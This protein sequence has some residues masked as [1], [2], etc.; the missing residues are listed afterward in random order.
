MMFCCKFQSAGHFDIKNALH[1]FNYA[2]YFLRQTGSPPEILA[3]NPQV[4][5]TPRKS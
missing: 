3:E 4:R 1:N 5:Q 2:P